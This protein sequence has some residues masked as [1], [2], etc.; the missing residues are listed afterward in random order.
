[1]KA[2]PVETVSIT[3]RILRRPAAAAYLGVGLRTLDG[4]IAQGL[5]PVVRIPGSPMVLFDVAELDR[6]IERNT[7]RERV[8]RVTR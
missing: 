1:M 6:W 7:E 4:W 3:P 2:P 8:V 5:L